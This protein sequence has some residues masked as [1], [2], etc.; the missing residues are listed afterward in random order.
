[1]LHSLSDLASDDAEINAIEQVVLRCFPR[2][3]EELH[4]LTSADVWGSTAHS[5][6]TARARIS[7][8]CNR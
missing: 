1:M 6:S 7:A 4:V 2:L 8:Y 5:T 3:A